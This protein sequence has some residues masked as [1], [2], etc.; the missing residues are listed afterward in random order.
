MNRSKTYS[1]NIKREKLKNKFHDLGGYLNSLKMICDV[2][3]FK[4]ENFNRIVQLFQRSNQFNFTTIRYS[5]N[6]IK[7]IT[8]DKKNISFQ[9]SFKDKFSNYGIVSLMVCCISKDELVI[10]NWVMSCRVLNRTLENFILNIL[11]KFCLKKKI[12]SIK[13]KFIQTEKNILV[14]NLFEE[15]GFKVT[16]KNK[17]EKEYIYFLNDHDHK[18]TYVKE[19]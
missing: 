2:G 13:S 16:N 17:N 5:L 6:Q 3:E 11:F 18:K 1:Q 19:L 10:S 14:K 8:Q 4:P 7:K 15:L 9:F 12:R